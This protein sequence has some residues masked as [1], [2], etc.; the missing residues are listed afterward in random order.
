[1][2]WCYASFERWCDLELCSENHFHFIVVYGQN[3][4]M[5]T[6]TWYSVVSCP[7]KPRDIGIKIDSL[8]D[9][10]RTLMLERINVR[11]RRLALTGS[12]GDTKPVGEGYTRCA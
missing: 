11:I 9:A 6:H 2:N 8:K 4:S 3:S 1:M 12:F 7:I 5:R 10:L